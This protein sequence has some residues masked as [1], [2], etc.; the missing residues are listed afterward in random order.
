MTEVY[1]KT[2]LEV[3]DRLMIVTAPVILMLTL[4][5][6]LCTGLPLAVL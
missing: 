5:V 1:S 6:W 4:F 2:Y 3:F